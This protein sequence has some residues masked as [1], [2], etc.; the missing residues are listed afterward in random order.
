MRVAAW[1]ALS[2]GLFGCAEGVVDSNGDSPRSCAA[3]D[4]GP[5]PL[6]RLTRTEYDNTVRDLLALDLRLAADN[7][8][9]DDA[10]HGYAANS[11]VPVSR[12]GVEDYMRSAEQ[13]AAAVDLSKVV[14][15]SSS[16]AGCIRAFVET[17]GARAYR[18]PLLPEEA[19][20]LVG[21]AEQR[22]GQTSF[23]D[24]VRLVIQ[25]VL[26]SPSFLYRVELGTPADSAD[27][28]TPLTD[29]EMASRLSYFL[30]S[31]MPDDTLL[32]AAAAGRLSDPVGLEAEARRMLD[33]DR[34][35]DGLVSFYEQWLGI[36]DLARL[37][38]D[39]ER[40]PEADAELLDAMYVETMVFVDAVM[41]SDDPSLSRLLTAD[42]SYVNARLADHYG[43][44]APSTD[45]NAWHRVALPEQERA[46]LLTHASLMTALADPDQTSPVL[47]G[48]FVRARLLC[49]APP[50][51]PP[52]ADIT[53]PAVDPTLPTKERWARH[54]QDPACSGCHELMDP[55]GLGFEHYDPIGRWTD[56]DGDYPV[57]SQGELVAA[58]DLS[59]PFDGALELSTL[60]AD[61]PQVHRCV[62]RQWVR[63]AL[64]RTELSEDACSLDT[65]DAAFSENELNLRELIVAI[66]RSDAFRYRRTEP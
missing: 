59:G 52:D 41:R 16:D 66:V 58:G 13:L 15:C 61:A 21:M 29:Y 14:R 33:D 5:T 19:D 48:K 8:E 42:F 62:A 43:I 35:R 47:R 57:D 32:A 64:G 46:G 4:V 56:Q 6:R 51:P 65:I 34:A 12:V 11:V 2:L 26:Q 10:T 63:F 28:V 55:I 22:A 20:S 31:S 3:P 38:K 17:F 27:P 7:F 53:P 39:P 50:P 37:Q 25:A 23:D 45:P 9:A 44:D 30:W 24:G 60:L 1:M 40:F 36:G 49:S 54:R 18:R